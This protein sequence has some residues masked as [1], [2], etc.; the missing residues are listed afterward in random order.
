M[1][2]RICLNYDLHIFFD[3]GAQPNGNDF[4]A[5]SN[6]RKCNLFNVN[7]G[8]CISCISIQ[9]VDIPNKDLIF[10]NHPYITSS[11]AAYLQDLNNFANRVLEFC[12]L[13]KMRTV[14]DIG[15][16]DGSLLNFF[17]KLGLDTIGVDPS[18]VSKL[19]SLSG[20]FELIH[21]FWGTKVSSKLRNDGYKIDIITSTASIYHM[22]D[23]HDWIKA[24]DMT[25]S[26]SG[27]FALQMVALDEVVENTLF[28]QF[29]HEHSFIHSLHSLKSLLLNYN[30]E[31]KFCEKNSSQGGSLFVIIGRRNS[32]LP[33]S[34]SINIQ[35]ENERHLSLNSF[36]K[37][38]N[39]TE[40]FFIRKKQLLTVLSDIKKKG[41]NIAALGAAL[42]GITLINYFEIDSSY[43]D[44]LIEV[45]P[46]K[47]D[48]YTAYFGI[49]VLEEKDELE[50]PKFLLVLSWTFRDYLIT[51]YNSYLV[52]GGTLIFPS[53]SLELVNLDSL[54]KV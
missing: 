24:V 44:F 41:H 28:D 9:L 12:N 27:I 38:N 26:E 7:Y 10:S 22:D 23:I 32:S 36:E 33:V 48:K 2:C 17:M 8:V 29:Y 6:Y 49:P 53:P 40:L 52:S 46:N 18:S 51:K 37:Y 13:H 39:F 1:K 16:N 43:L 25:L 20:N 50:L 14:L 5:K 42:R 47:I 35:L 4:L 31:L 21:E 11:S 45:N 54:G 30:L 3:L 15:C 34:P 19:A